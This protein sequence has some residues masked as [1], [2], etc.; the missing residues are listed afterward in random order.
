MSPAS[1]Q[2]SLLPVPRIVFL[3]PRQATALVQDDDLAPLEGM[4]A[5]RDPATAATSPA[6]LWPW[7][8]LAAAL[9]AAAILAYRLRNRPPAATAAESPL[10]HARHEIQDC[11]AH[12]E[13][14]DA[15]ARFPD[16]LSRLLRDYL[17]RETALPFR[18]AVTPE[19]EPM[20]ASV[21]PAPLAHDLAR[22]CQDC[23]ARRFTPGSP[24]AGVA[25]RSEMLAHVRALIDETARARLATIAS[26]LPTGTG[27]A[28]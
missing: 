21:L 11:A 12:I 23:D 14:A 7:L 22:F 13:D 15:A 6:L 17:E 27:G 18:A 1:L 19:I 2:P 28:P 24:V 25:T 9:A 16:R 4:L 26:T 5:H 20:A 10:A 3:A 8:C